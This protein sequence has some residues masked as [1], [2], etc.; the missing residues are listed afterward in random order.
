MKKF[1]SCA[2]RVL[3]SGSAARVVELVER[4]DELDDVHELMALVRT[5]R[6]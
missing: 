2:R 5:T 4:L 6:R 3:D 1:H